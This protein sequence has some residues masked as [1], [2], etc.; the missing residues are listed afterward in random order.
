V[1]SGT[2]IYQNGVKVAPAQTNP[3]IKPGTGSWLN[4]VP[5]VDAL[6]QQGETLVRD[7][8]A[9]PVP[10]E[11]KV[12]G[13]GAT[14]VDL[15]AS[16]K[17]RMGWALLII[18][19]SMFVL[20]FLA[21]GSVFLPFKALVTALFSLSASFG[22]L[23]W[24]FQDGHWSGILN[25]TATGMVDATMPILMFC[26]A[27]GLSMDYE[28]FLLSRIKEEHD[29]GQ[30]NISAVA[31]GLEKTGGI[32]TA[33]AI[34]ISVIFIAFATS[35]VMIIKMLGL[36]LAIAVLLD[37][38]VIRATLVPAFMRLA[39]NLN[40]WAPEPLARLYRRFNISE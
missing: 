15:K 28:M 8:R 6:S 16:L 31:H 4:V 9:V 32:V 25:F 3:Y 24:I 7:I 11:V 37:A 10:F 35:G 13:F 20:F 18:A 2:G 38:F 22:A 33:A 34:S 30:D 5:N 12:G 1:E 14:L 21:F 36:G 29:K 40:W 23:V 39:G 26:I 17:A 19:V 27:F